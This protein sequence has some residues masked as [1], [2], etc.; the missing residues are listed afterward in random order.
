MSERAVV[1]FRGIDFR[2][3]YRLLNC[4]R[5]Q[6]NHLHEQHVNKNVLIGQTQHVVGIMHREMLMTSAKL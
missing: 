2:R 6:I 5:L 1:L 4:N 3:R